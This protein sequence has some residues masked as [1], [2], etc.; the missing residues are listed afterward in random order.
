M[1]AGHGA[2]VVLKQPCL[3]THE[4]CARPPC[5]NQ[6]VLG[7]GIQST[8]MLKR[9]MTLCSR[10]WS[11]RHLL[12]KYGCVLHQ[13]I[14]AL[15]CSKHKEVMFLVD[16]VASFL[17][18]VR[19]YHHAWL[20]HFILFCWFGSTCSGTDDTFYAKVHPVKHTGSV[21]RNKFIKDTCAEPLILQ[22]KKWLRG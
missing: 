9:N 15:N 12:S 6:E 11:W 7:C 18:W 16:L 10:C 22:S 14:D 21:I 5:P 1:Y 20:T 19:A 3:G 17:F 8:L 4:P 2:N 13:D